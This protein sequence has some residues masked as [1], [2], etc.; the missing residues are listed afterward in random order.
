MQDKKTLS[1]ACKFPGCVAQE[2][3]PVHRPGGAANLGKSCERCKGTGRANYKPQGAIH[4]ITDLCDEC[5]GT[6]LR[7]ARRST[8]TPKN[9]IV[10]VDE[11]PL[12]Q[13]SQK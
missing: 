5:G 7:D 10:P 12:I 4:I 6:G 11:R 8:R 3:C 9:E 1:R 2:P 13:E